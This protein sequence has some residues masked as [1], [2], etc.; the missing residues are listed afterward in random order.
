MSRGAVVLLLVL[1]LAAPAV[2]C[3][4]DDSWTQSSVC[5]I[6]AIG[7]LAAATHLARPLVAARRRPPA[8]AEAIFEVPPR[9]PDPP[10]K[11]GARPG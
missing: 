1:A 5:D 4:H 10:P 2:L 6:H 8:G 9:L 11:A 7:G 3:M